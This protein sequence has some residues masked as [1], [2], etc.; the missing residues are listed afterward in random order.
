[1]AGILNEY[2]EKR[3]G[4][5]DLFAELDRLVKEYNK[6]TGRYLFIF[7]S[8]LAKARRGIND[9]AI[10]Q[11]DFYNIQ[12][13]LRECA[14]KEID[15][16]LETP[17]GSGEAAEEIARF[18]HR[19][20]ESIRFIVCGEA[21]SAGTLLVLSGDEILMTDSGSLGPI[22][23]QVTIGRHTVSAYDYKAWVES[24]RMEAAK[25][26]KL[27]PFDAVMVAQISPGEI[28]GVYN[29][30]EFATD[31]VKKWLV[32]H[33][34]KNWKV[35]SSGK[36]VS[37]EKKKERAEEIANLLCDHMTWRSHGR[38]LKIDDLKQY[39][40]IERID[41]NQT[42]ADVVYRLSIVI[43]LIFSNSSIYKIYKTADTFLSKTAL[44][45]A[46]AASRP[47]PFPMGPNK[48]QPKVQLQK[49]DLRIK[50]PKCNKEHFVP[51]YID[52][53]SSQI[54]ALNLQVNKNVNDNNVLVCDECGFELDLKPI[55]NQFEAQNR[56]SLNF[57]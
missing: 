27:N 49:A 6:L 51:G 12:D 52:I 53:P 39:L 57:K 10:F 33:K 24:K 1:M 19:K 44:I 8:D 21:K 29:S 56:K 4:T 46:S 31:L 50:C 22:D 37:L 54:K 38:S 30:L 5:Q 16:Y 20:F 41:D 45:N 55:K 17:G 47:I 43:R 32:E 14:A 2:I 25:N 28:Y 26:G 36:V 9:I 48:V 23:A 34:F 11:E 42:L 7:S 13:I 40:K 35:T 3:L 18:L 15:V